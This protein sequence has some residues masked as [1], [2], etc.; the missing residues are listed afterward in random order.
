VSLDG[1]EKVE[2]NVLHQIEEE[3]EDQL[4]CYVELVDV[5]NFDL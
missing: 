5:T 3:F 4:D 1:F 2:G